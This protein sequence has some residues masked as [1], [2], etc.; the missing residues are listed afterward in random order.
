MAWKLKNRPIQQVKL[1][2]SIGLA[3]TS[4]LQEN[5]PSNSTDNDIDIFTPG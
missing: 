2:T 4:Q 5:S 3:S 1:S